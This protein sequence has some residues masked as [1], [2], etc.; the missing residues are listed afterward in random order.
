MKKESELKLKMLKTLEFDFNE[1]ESAIQVTF[2]AESISIVEEIKKIEPLFDCELYVDEI[3]KKAIED[4][5]K[6]YEDK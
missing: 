4:S 5:L 2:S 6:D 3:V 1:K